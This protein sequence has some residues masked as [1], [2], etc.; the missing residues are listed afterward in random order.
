M[1]RTEKVVRIR[2][3][4]QFFTAAGKK[5]TEGKPIVTTFTHTMSNTI[6]LTVTTTTTPTPTVMA[7]Q[8]PS[9][10]ADILAEARRRLLTEQRKAHEE[11]A[12]LRERELRAMTEAE[13]R[14]R[15][16]RIK[17]RAEEE[18][19]AF[20]ARRLT[21]DADAKAAADKREAAI[22]AEIARL[23]SRTQVEI[24]EDKVAALT[25]A[26]SSLSD[27]RLKEIR[28]RFD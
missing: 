1:F 6:N 10:D 23:K 15:E 17:L 26:L 12:L 18:M 24:L 14:I 9:T 7:E 13:A 20:M 11:S 19:V 4:A 22:A 8:R 21:L 2:W 5:L 3:L 16:E 28:A 27:P 25:E